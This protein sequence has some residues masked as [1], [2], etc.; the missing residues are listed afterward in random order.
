MKVYKLTVMI[1]DFDQTGGEEIVTELENANY[2][3]DCISPS[4]MA[5]EERDIGEWD[6]DHPLNK[7]GNEKHF[8]DLFK[9]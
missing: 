1:I 7:S 8:F 4:V 5:I 6:D 2:S 9:K 3:N